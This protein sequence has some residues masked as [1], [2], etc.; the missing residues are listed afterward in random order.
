MVG[1]VGSVGTV[2]ADEGCIVV[3]GRAEIGSVVG[4]MVVGADCPQ[5]DNITAKSI[6]IASIAAITVL[7]F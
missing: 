7:H 6:A 1:C 5:P 2:A 4:R 3:V